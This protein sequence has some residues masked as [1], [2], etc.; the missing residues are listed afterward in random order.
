[1]RCRVWHFLDSYPATSKTTSCYQVTTPIQ[2]PNQFLNY[3]STIPKRCLR[4][5]LSPRLHYCLGSKSLVEAAEPRNNGSV[6]IGVKTLGATKL[7]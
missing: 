6:Y 3:E 7:H 4:K 1:M 5:R 2:V